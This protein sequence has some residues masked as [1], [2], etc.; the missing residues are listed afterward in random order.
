MKLSACFDGMTASS[1]MDTFSFSF[2][3]ITDIDKI[4][5]LD[6]KVPIRNIKSPWVYQTPK[7]EGSSFRNCLM[8]NP[9]IS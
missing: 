5:V 3:F 9:L 7:T 1:I 2:Y 6:K 4:S 8:L